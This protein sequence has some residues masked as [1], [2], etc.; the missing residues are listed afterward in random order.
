MSDCS[1]VLSCESTADYPRAFFEQ[2][3]IAWVPFHYTIDGVSHPDDLYTSITPEAF[4]NQ[5][6]AGAQPTT[7]QVGVGEYE[8]FWEPF[9]QEGKDVLHLT[10]SSGISGSYNSACIAAEQLRERYP[11]RRVCVVDS[12]AASAGFGLLVEYLADL[13]DGGMSFDDACAWVEEHKLNLNHWFFVSDLDCL[14]RG[15][16]VSAT[17]ALLA[18]ALKICPVLNVDYQGKL[19][20]RQKIRTVKRAIAE[21]VRMMEEHAEGG[22]AYAGKCCLSQSNCRGEAEAVVAGIEERFP[23]LAG[24]IAIYDIGTVIGAHTGPGTVA[25]FFMGDKRVD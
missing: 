8:E 6:K 18:N 17:S 10:L 1:Y 7:S 19:I 20:P 3:D 11:E 12:L 22:L 21:L 14:K 15:G 23:Q 24:K 9:L 16:R 4:F 2:R 5:I 13:R 25:L